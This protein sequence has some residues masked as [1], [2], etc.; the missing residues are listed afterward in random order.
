MRC[1]AARRPSG[2]GPYRQTT[3]S[4]GGLTGSA[5]RRSEASPPGREQGDPVV[6]NAAVSHQTARCT[7]RPLFR[8]ASCSGQQRRLRKQPWSGGGARLI[9][10][11]VLV[12]IKQPWSGGGARLIRLDVLVAIKQLPP[13]T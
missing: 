8:D 4:D 11:D 3:P 2:P 5:A 7:W 13:M 9:R 6:G 10:L 1:G 12:A